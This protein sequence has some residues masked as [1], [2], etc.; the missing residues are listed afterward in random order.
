MRNCGAPSP[1]A[2]TSSQRHGSSSS[3][4][5][6]YPA[7]VSAAPDSAADPNSKTVASD[8]CRCCRRTSTAPCAPDAATASGAAAPA[9]AGV[10]W[11]R[12]SVEPPRRPPLHHEKSPIG[13]EDVQTEIGLGRPPAR[14]LAKAS[15]FAE[16]SLF[17]PFLFGKFFDPADAFPLWDFEPEVL[18]ASLRRAAA[19]TTVDW[20]ETDSEYYLRTD[21]P[22]GRKCEVEVS[23]DAMKVIDISGLWRAPPA[24]GRD[25]RAGRWWEHGFVRRVELPEDADW[26]KVEAYFDDGDGSLEIKVPK[27]GDAHQATA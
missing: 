13:N 15:V 19:R 14:T 7:S 6:Q 25:W 12:C 20:A 17:S 8:A 9:A 16:G 22:G 27:N 2:G 1:V 4:T 5:G 21:I 10:D 3:D 24:D 11:L 26:R 18:L 23:G